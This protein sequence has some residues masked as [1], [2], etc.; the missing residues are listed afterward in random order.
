MS[1]KVNV[2][3]GPDEL[4]GVP[5]DMAMDDL[6]NLGGAPN[7]APVQSAGTPINSNGKSTVRLGGGNVIVAAKAPNFMFL[8][9][10]T[11]TEG[12]GVVD[13][14]DVSSPG[15]RRFDTN[16]FLPGI[17]SIPVSGITGL[18]NYWRQ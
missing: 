1:F 14:I 13:V 17:Q 6:L 5:T 4:T 8:A 15:Y 11:S 10:P 3:I 18:C 16:V 12:P 7:Q 2:S 9:V